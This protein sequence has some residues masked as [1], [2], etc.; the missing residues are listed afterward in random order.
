[1]KQYCNQMFYNKCAIN[2]YYSIM[3]VYN[4]FQKY[5]VNVKN[6]VISRI[7]RLM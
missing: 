1:V 5:I 3:A 4:F 6:D 7:V 2:F